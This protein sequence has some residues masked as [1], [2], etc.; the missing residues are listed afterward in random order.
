MQAFRLRGIV[1]DSA[2]FFS[3]DALRWDA[4]RQGVLSPIRNLVFGDPNGLTEDEKSTNGRIL[5][6]YV[7]AN[8]KKLG[9]DM[10]EG[11]KDIEVPSFHP[12]FRIGSDGGLKIDMVIEAVQTRYAP[13]DEYS[14]ALGTFPMR[15]GVTLLVAHQS[16]RDDGTRPDPEIRYVVHNHLSPERERRQRMNYYATGRVPH[17]HGEGDGHHHGK[18]A[19][20][21]LDES[22]FQIDF[23]LIHAGI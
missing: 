6:D 15:G 3:D 21:E 11:G 19:E 12:T 22:H 13:L 16:L 14:D 17:F 2:K 9:F 4:V 5:R 20:H 10:S 1:A 18:H 23:G 7:R 8:G